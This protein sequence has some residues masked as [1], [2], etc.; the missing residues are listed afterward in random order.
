M[1]ENRLA[2]GKKEGTQIL[3][4]PEETTGIADSK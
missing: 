1:S 2:S 3:P 4:I